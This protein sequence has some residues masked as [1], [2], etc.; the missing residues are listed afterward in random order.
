M[1]T[2]SQ[3]E[4]VMRS[5]A[6]TTKGKLL[7]YT[8]VVALSLIWGLAFV[9]IRRAAFELSPV[10]LTIIRWLIASAGFLLLAPIFGKAQK[11]HSEAARSANPPGLFR[12]CYGVSS[13]TELC[14]VHRLVGSG[15]ASH[16]LWTDFCRTALGSF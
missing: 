15:W 6:T 9:A 5:P 10:N 13:F 11:A 7:G 2:K 12:E 14:R 8:L 1:E 3:P 4:T 16:L